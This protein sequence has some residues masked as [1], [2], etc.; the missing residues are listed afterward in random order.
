[1]GIA[2]PALVP[3]ASSAAPPSHIAAQEA[4]A[5]S[6]VTLPQNAD[7]AGRTVGAQLAAKLAAQKAAA[8]AARKAAAKARLEA[9][10]KARRAAAARRA[11]RSRSFARVSYGSPRAIARAQLAARGWGDQFGCLDSLWQRES[12]WSVSAANASGAYGIPQALP[13]SKMASEGSDWRTNPA[14]QIEWG[15]SYIRGS[16]GSPCGAWDFKQ[17]HGW[18]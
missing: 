14:T 7:L 3:L 15:L 8:Q 5:P 11:S 1:M 6:V 18:Y 2:G 17:G 4:V 16:Y 12:G 9:A 13:G 10:A